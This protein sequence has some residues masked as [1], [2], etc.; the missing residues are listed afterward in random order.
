MLLNNSFNNED[1]IEE[2]YLTNC[3]NFFLNVK[4][5]QDTADWYPD[6]YRVNYP[7]KDVQIYDLRLW[8][9]LVCG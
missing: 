1:G 3:L 4:D 9:F 2:V 6:K 5:Y 7:R 8:K